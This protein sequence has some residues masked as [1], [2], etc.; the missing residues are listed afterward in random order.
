MIRGFL[1]I[2]AL[3]A[4]V[5]CAQGA[6]TSRQA[7]VMP[8]E[9][10]TPTFLRHVA[11]GTEGAAAF[12]RLEA[13]EEYALSRSGPADDPIVDD[14]RSFLPRPDAA[15]FVT[16][17]AFRTA[18]DQY[19]RRG[20]EPS[21]GTRMGVQ[22]ESGREDYNKLVGE[23]TTEID[24]SNAAW[25]KAEI[26]RRG[27]WIL[28]SEFG[29]VAATHLWLLFQHADRDV[30][31]QKQALTM[32]EPLVAT[33]GVSGA[34]YAYLY[35]RVATNTGQL[36]RYGTQGGCVEGGGW[37]P[38]PIEDADLVNARRAGRGITQTMAEYIQTFIDQ[39]VCQ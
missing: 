15:P 27:A 5:A 26:E 12:A 38:R 37:E 36:Q 14:V 16:E 31:F 7:A 35:D 24:A 20:F 9:R 2:T 19:W 39:G 25:V 11:V 22:T 8:S 18:R 6:E 3:L 33:G 29:P 21:V 4:G 32:M 17:L 28:Q 1:V 13:L 30:D 10:T 34:H 23:R